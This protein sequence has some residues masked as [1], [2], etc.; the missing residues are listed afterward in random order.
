VPRLRRE[1]AGRR[2]TGPGRVLVLIYCIF[3]VAATSRAAVQIA[4][5]YSDAPLAYLLSG[6]AAVV[7]IV[8]AVALAR[9]G[10]RA[11]R[12]AVAC[13]SF[14][15]F[16][17]LT[18]GTASLLDPEAFPDATVWSAYG[19]GYGFVPLV[20]PVLGLLYLRSQPAAGS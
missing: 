7:Y 16:G 13:C 2:D 20:L 15:L 3:A 17:V 12:A 9:P 18:V 14:E 4:T 11:H 10:P 19:I 5:K 1:A 8:A 6:L